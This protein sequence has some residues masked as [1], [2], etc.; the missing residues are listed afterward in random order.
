MKA[1]KIIVCLLTVH[2]CDGYFGNRCSAQEHLDG[3]ESKTE[4]FKRL[5]A[6]RENSSGFHRPR[7]Y[8]YE[9]FFQERL[10][11]EKDFT[12]QATLGEIIVDPRS[13]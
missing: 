6:F 1:Y 7:S 10:G 12:L 4:F 8:C 5:D 9:L 11:I 13:R 2:L 3:K